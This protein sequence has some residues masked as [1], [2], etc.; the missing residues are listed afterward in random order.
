MIKVTMSAYRALIAEKMERKEPI[1]PLLRSYKVIPAFEPT[2]NPVI[3]GF[4]M[5]KRMADAGNEL[6]YGS[7]VFDIGDFEWY[8]KKFCA[9]A[10]LFR[11]GHRA[12]LADETNRCIY[13]FCEGDVSVERTPDAGAF[14]KAVEA[15]KKFYA[16]E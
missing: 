3:D 7:H 5:E 10:P 12:V 2:G 8:V 6:F 9:T 1:G 4:C 14:S 15:A 13:T 16:N 11:D